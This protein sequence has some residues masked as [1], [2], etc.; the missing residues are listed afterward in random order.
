MQIFWFILI[1]RA[2]VSK[3]KE[4]FTCLSV[5]VNEVEALYDLFKKLSSSI[6]DDGFIHKEE[7][8]LALFRNRSK[9]NLFADRVFDLFDIKRNGVI[10]FGEFVRSLSIFHPNAPNEDKREFAFKLYDLRQT[11]YIE[12]EELRDMVSAILSE[13]NLEISED[14]VESI[15]DKTMAEADLKGDG[16]IDKEE[17]K[18]FVARNP[19]IL[20]NMTLPCLKQITI[21]FPSF[22]LNSVVQDSDIVA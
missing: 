11:G 20:R 19:S 7:F 2:N 16:K 6:I 14:V 13:S 9:Q 3:S 4:L 12:H 1:F 17:W 21:A 22:V 18:E 15:V 10:E 8:Q 5:T